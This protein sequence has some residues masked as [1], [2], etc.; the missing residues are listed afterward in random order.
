MSTLNV[1]FKP[2]VYNDNGAIAD[3]A[4]PDYHFRSEEHTSELQSP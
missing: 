1:M 4:N 3:N 2:G